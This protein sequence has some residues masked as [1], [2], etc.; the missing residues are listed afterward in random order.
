M[1]NHKENE[2]YT[3]HQRRDSIDKA[4]DKNV[5]HYIIILIIAIIGLVVWGSS[6][7]K[8]DPDVMKSLKGAALGA[9]FF[10]SVSIAVV[11]GHMANVTFMGDSIETVFGRLSG[12]GAC[13]STAAIFLVMGT[14]AIVS[15][16]NMLGI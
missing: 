5:I 7:R 15:I 10:L 1:V 16:T 12:K 14:T 3:I 4:I 13:L 11:A 8:S 2:E 6:L 9:G